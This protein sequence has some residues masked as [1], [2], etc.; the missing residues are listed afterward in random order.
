MCYS[1]PFLTSHLSCIIKNTFMS[2]FITAHNEMSLG[3]CIA[4]GSQHFL[5]RLIQDPGNSDGIHWNAVGALQ[6]F[7]MGTL[8]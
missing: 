8:C 2:H 3:L 1:A 4:L 7:M 5:V 6:I